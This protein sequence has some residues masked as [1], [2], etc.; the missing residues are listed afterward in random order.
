MY[1][2]HIFSL[3]SYLFFYKIQNP[4]ENSTSVATTHIGSLRRMGWTASTEWKWFQIQSNPFEKQTIT[5]GK[6]SIKEPQTSF[7]VELP[8]QQSN[9]LLALDAPRYKDVRRKLLPSHKDKYVISNM[10]QLSSRKS[11]N[12]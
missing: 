6:R 8:K 11:S 9:S 12:R 1:F 2:F 3:D 4:K 10:L 7:P 5:L